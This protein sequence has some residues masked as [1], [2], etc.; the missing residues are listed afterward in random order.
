MIPSIKPMDM[1]GIKDSM[2]L[3]KG[4]A[5]MPKVMKVYGN[6]NCKELGQRF[7]SPVI[8]KMMSDYLPEEYTAYSLLVSY[9]TMT[10]GNGKIPMKGSLA[11]LLRMAARY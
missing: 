1:M 10:S 8:R 5:N 11:M 2:E 9:G 7:K 4:M 6:I 3:G